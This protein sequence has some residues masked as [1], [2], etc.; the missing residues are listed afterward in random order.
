VGAG[1]EAFNS[2]S[3]I[4]Q[5]HPHQQYSREPVNRR[6]LRRRHLSIDNRSSCS[7]TVQFQ[8]E[9]EFLRRQLAEEEAAAERRRRTRNNR[10]RHAS[11]ESKSYRHAGNQTANDLSVACDCGV[12]HGDDVKQQLESLRGLIQVY[13]E[14]RK[15]ER[16]KRRWQKKHGQSRS[17]SC[18]VDSRTN[19]E[20]LEKRSTSPY[21]NGMV[22]NMGDGHKTL[23]EAGI[24]PPNTVPSPCSFGAPE[25]VSSAAALAKATRV[26]KERRKHE[27]RSE[28]ILTALFVALLGVAAYLL[29]HS[30]G[31]TAPWFLS[32]KE[33]HMEP[34]YPTG[35]DVSFF[36]SPVPTVK[37]YAVYFAEEVMN[38]VKHVSRKLNA[39]EAWSR[40]AWEAHKKRFQ[41]EFDGEDGKSGSEAAK[42]SLVPQPDE[43]AANPFAPA[44]SN[45]KVS[46]YPSTDHES[47]PGGHTLDPSSQKK[48]TRSRFQKVDPD[49]GMRRPRKTPENK[50]SEERGR[51]FSTKKLTDLV[52]T[53]NNVPYGPT[54]LLHNPAVEW[55]KVLWKYVI[56]WVGFSVDLLLGHF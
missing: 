45:D 36:G 39:T 15:E 50:G 26:T 19:R 2:N 47:K 27:D 33:E 56:S 20:V 30:S 42:T 6:R 11:E 49:D 29:Q 41:H 24:G 16:A 53:L 25:E 43:E 17:T 7:T 40:S 35:K 34:R 51:G 9:T 8:R 14:R 1:G 22:M 52:D 5:E 23:V 55:V 21:S 4:Y 31:L 32:P 54:D 44:N 38:M 37:N 13:L 28:A 46:S 18:V 12:Q 48:R 3:H 10:S